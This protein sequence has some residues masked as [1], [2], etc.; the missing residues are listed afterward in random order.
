MTVHRPV[1]T[2]FVAL[3]L[4]LGIGTL[5]LSAC[6]TSAEGACDRIAEACHDKDTGSGK[7]HDCH[8]A[9]EASTATEASCAALETECLAACM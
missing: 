7:P 6:D 5:T 8:E 3:S 1:R 2:L 4:L 9:V